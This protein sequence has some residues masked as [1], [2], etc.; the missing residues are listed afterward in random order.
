[1]D[2]SG[3]DH[4]NTP[5]EVR[6]GIAL[7]DEQLWPFV[8]SVRDAEI[9]CFGAP[10]HEY[11][12]ELKGSRL[13]EK[14]RFEWAGY[15]T[16]LVARE[17]QALARAFLTKGLEK[18]SPTKREFAAYGQA[19]IAMA[20]R[21]FFLLEKHEAKLFAAAIGCDV[22][23]Q[24]GSPGEEIL[25]KDH[26]FLL[27][28]YYYFLEGVNEHGLIVMD[29][30]DKREDRKFVRRLERYFTVTQT[31]IERTHR[32]VPVPFFVSSDMAYPV[33]VADVCIYCVNWG[34]RLPTQGMNEPVRAEIAR[35]FGPLL[36]KI[37]YR[38]DGYKEGQ[39][40]RTWG[41]LY[42]PNPCGPGK[43]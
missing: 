29:E 43:W 13:L 3:H 10:L 23:A 12:T 19:S 21:L 7:S 8:Q 6:G 9:E 18:K 17:R 30:T 40:F 1:M 22:E 37:Q 27:E 20:K 33:Q 36:D 15:E 2:E 16:P 42:V 31:G 34:Y 4:K 35:E 32:I 5:Y 38:G 28:R 39:V 26:V 41:I 24:P 14:A 11:K 25:R